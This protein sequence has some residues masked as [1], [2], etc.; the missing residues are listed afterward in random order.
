MSSLNTVINGLKVMRN[1]GWR[2]IA[3]RSVHELNRRSGR[4]K[5]RFPQAPPF[6]RYLS[7]EEWQKQSVSF[8]FHSREQVKVPRCATPELAQRFQQIKEG[9]LS[10]FNGVVLPIG[11]D[12]SWMKNPDTGFV[13]DETAHWTEIN[14]YS[15]VAGDIKYVWEKARFAYLY[16]IIRYD[17]HFGEDNAALVFGDILSWIKANPVNSGPHYK[18]SQEISLRVLNWTFALY[19]YRHSAA[20]TTTV[21]DQIQY[22]IY[23]QLHHVY[24]NINFSRIAVR[25]NH[26]ITE[27]LALYLGG[28]LYPALPGAA[29]WKQQGRQWFEEEIGY[30]IYED[31]TFLQFSMNYHRVVVQLLTWG[32]QLAALNRESF[33]PVVQEKAAKSL[34]FLRVCMNDSNGWLPNY[35][36]NDGAL[37]FRL[38]DQHYRDYRPQLQALSVLLQLD[39]E[40]PVCYE[41]VYW[42]GLQPGVWGDTVLEKDRV[43]YQFHEGGYFV[44]REQSTLTMLRCGNHKDRPSQADNLHLDIWHG[45]ENLLMDAGSYKYNTDAETLRYFMGTASHNTVMLD[46]YDQMQKG[47]RFIWYNWTQCLRARLYETEEE[48]VWEGAIHAFQQV[49]P[50]IMHVRQVRKKKGA[51]VWIVKDYI[52]HKPA[53]AVMRQLWHTMCPEKMVLK[54]EDS[55]RSLLQPLYKPGWYA[56]LYG[57]RE[58]NHAI[59]FTTSA[60]TIITEIII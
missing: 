19:F 60:D 39:A 9:K 1:M 50:D 20:L 58:D 53:W 37:F 40:I 56:S 36:A 14:D 7:L 16:D 55:H 4:L 17:H 34:R 11:K 18:C 43:L 5:K 22:A 26:A 54:A 48:Y 23:W 10:F 29:A 25:N 8:F 2:Y 13:Y 47:P 46:N 12:F 44:C 59:L 3:F 33:A 42:Y 15:A 57:A 24:H 41:E 35:G 31:G 27:T 51:Q 30:Q 49:A 6:Q 28:L 52:Q 38:S 21:F 32:L 45:E